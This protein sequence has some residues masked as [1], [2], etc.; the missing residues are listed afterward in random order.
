MVEHKQQSLIAGEAAQVV[1]RII[2]GRETRGSF[3][4]SDLFADAAWDILLDLF[5][6]QLEGR[7]AEIAEL[8]F[9]SSIPAS[10]ARRWVDKLEKDGWLKQ[11]ADPSEP[12]R[13]WVA[14]SGQGTRK[15]Q[16]WFNDWVEH[17]RSAPDGDPVRDLLERIE[18]SRREN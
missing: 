13:R 14:L 16:A 7:N 10:T 5:L 8:R 9:S 6:A 11:K 3:F 1:L 4:D 17:Q 2:E 12:D 15:M 18:R